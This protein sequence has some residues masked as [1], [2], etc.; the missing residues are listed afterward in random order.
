MKKGEQ[1]KKVSKVCL[2]CGVT[3]TKRPR[4]PYHV[5]ALRKYCSNKCVGKAVSR[6]N[7]NALGHKH[8]E[9][10]K[11]KISLAFT[12]EKHPFWAGG[13]DRFPDCLKCGKKLSSFKSIHCRKHAFELKR[14]ENHPNWV[15]ERTELLNRKLLRNSKKMK[16]WRM[17]VFERDDF[18][19][20]E[21]GIVGGYLEA[22]HIKS[23][24]HYPEERFNLENGQTLCKP[25]HVNTEN[26]KGKNLIKTN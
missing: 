22:H 14:G 15:K 8:S 2:E 18:T 19:C 13:K 1:K 6:G 3:F 12:G 11:K 26:Y 10:A 5:F 23:F 25:C 7:Q 20:Q 9:E 21:C 24:A 17:G 4:Y 16:E